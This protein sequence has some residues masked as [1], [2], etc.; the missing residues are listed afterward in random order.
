M[1]CAGAGCNYIWSGGLIKEFT[2][3][4]VP[5]YGDLNRGLVGLLIH[6]KSAKPTTLQL[7]KYIY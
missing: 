2:T 4:P 5:F 7:T 6:C 3:L 1:G